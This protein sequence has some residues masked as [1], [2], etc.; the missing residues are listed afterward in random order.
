MGTRK[1]NPSR[2][3]LKKTAKVLRQNSLE[4]YKNKRNFKKTPEPKGKKKMAAKAVARPELRFVVQKH[5]ARRLHYDFRLEIDGVLKSWAV[6]KG[7]PV[8]RGDKRLAIRVEDHPFEY[9]HFEGIIPSGNYGGGTVMVWDDGT[10][11]VLNGTPGAALKT[12]KIEM[13]F[14]G[15]KMRGTW[16]LIRTKGIGASAKEAWLLIKSAQDLPSWS[17]RQENT[18]VLTRRTMEE[19]AKA[20]DAL[21]RGESESARRNAHVSHAH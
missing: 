8:K 3:S 10:Y 4:E 18:S 6:P 20:Q 13:K 12:G 14:S 9:A 5:A 7:L 15:K 1:K 17:D 11:E 21:W 16:T 19:I 2:L